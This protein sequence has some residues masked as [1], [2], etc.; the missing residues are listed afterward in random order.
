MSEALIAPPGVEALLLDYVPELEKFSDLALEE[1]MIE[2]LVSPAVVD[3]LSCSLLFNEIA[4]REF[5]AFS[6]R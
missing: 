1:G 2:A 5:R 3:G 4:N 6:E